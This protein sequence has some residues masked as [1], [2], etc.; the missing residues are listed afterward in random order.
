MES[1]SMESFA[2]IFRD[3]VKTKGSKPFCFILGAGASV[4][5]GIPSGK[6][7]CREWW[8]EI[9]G[10][11]EAER[12]ACAKREEVAEDFLRIFKKNTYTPASTDYDNMYKLRYGAD[13]ESGNAFL[14]AQMEGKSPSYGYYLLAS[15]LSQTANRVVIT[16]NFDSLLE[17]A[18]FS[19][20][21]VRPLVI[22]HE[23]LVR[24]MQFNGDTPTILKIHRDLRYNPKNT[25]EDL[26][27]GWK[28]LLKHELREYTPVVIGYGGGDN[29]LMAVLR[30]KSPL[31]RLYWL[32]RSAP[33]P[34]IEEIITRHHGNWVEIEGFDKAMYTLCRE[35]GLPDVL[36]TMEEMYKSRKEKFV[37]SLNK[38][39]P[40]PGGSPGGAPMPSAELQLPA[41]A[42]PELE[43]MYVSALADCVFDRYKDALEKWNK[44]CE[45]NPDKAECYHG[46]GM[47]LLELG[48][49]EEALKDM[50]KAIELSPDTA[51]Y[52]E[53]RG[54]TLCVLG[55][56]EEALKDTDKAIELAPDV[57][58]P[59]CI[60]AITLRA[61]GRDAEAE[62]ALDKA[63]EIALRD[64]TP[65][66]P[67]YQ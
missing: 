25:T 61:L 45:K 12:L 31:D 67:D 46:R 41:D 50:A 24:Y 42:S 13:P 40:D 37:A 5:S 58:M 51:M 22:G 14:R 7:F 23:S 39:R 65:I 19:V 49:Y 20:H 34:E 32:K 21:P 16:T 66:T 63:D 8:N 33:E 28:N 60:R 64:C 36:D 17:D 9:H 62:A 55:R 4:E 30:E 2:R 35:L 15:V 54:K 6:T 44:L 48:C 38:I 52:Y 3:R 47:T 59:Y 11:S 10:W 27:G 56:Y 43:K 53:D 18:L 26:S 29:T 1:I 57:D